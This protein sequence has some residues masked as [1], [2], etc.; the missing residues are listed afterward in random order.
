MKPST[1][2][3]LLVTSFIATIGVITWREIKTNKRV[4]LPSR[5][6][7][8]SVAFAMLG[9]AEPIISPELASIL[10]AAIVMAVTVRGKASATN[11]PAGGSGSG[12]QGG[13]GG[14]A[15]GGGGG[16]F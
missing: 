8:A 9:I 7:G 6:V 3:G 10:G 13:S 14:G 1:G 16:S 2:K 4:P 5:Y 15:G 11:G 12:G